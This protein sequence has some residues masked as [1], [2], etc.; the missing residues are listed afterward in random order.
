[1]LKPLTMDN[2][3]CPFCHIDREIIMRS[4]HC[5]SI[6]D[7]EDPSGGVRHLIPKKGKYQ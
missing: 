1:M 3:K 2:T 5:F 6:Y 7:M 4:D